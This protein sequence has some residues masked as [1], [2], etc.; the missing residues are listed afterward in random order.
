QWIELHTLLQGY[1]LS[2]QGDRMA[3]AHGV[4]PRCPFLSTALV[5]YA[6]QLPERYLLS[7]DGD[8]KHLLKHAFA[9]ALPRAITA[10]PK[11]PYRA[12]DAAS[13][14]DPADPSRFRDWV[15]ELLGE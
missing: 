7:D 6:A 5:S 12:P 11:Q 8:E 15:E 3:F 9:D 4:E 13:F 14:R 1:L 10:K 2:S